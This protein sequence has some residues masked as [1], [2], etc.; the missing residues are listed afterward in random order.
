VALGRLKVRLLMVA[1]PE[2][3]PKVRLAASPPIVRS[4]A[5][6]VKMVAVAAVVVKSPP[7]TATSPLVVILPVPPVILK[8]VAVTSLAPRARA[9]T[10]SVSERS[11]PEV[12]PP[13]AAW[14]LI[15][16]ARISLA[17]RFS[18]SSN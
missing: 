14:T 17:S 4:V 7:L 13:A 5:P 18:T 2:L 12:I 8:L 10:R 1:V 6:V 15:P 3:S 16:A 11:I 9:L